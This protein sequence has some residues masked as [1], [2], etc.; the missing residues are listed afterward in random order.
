ML[1]NIGLHSVNYNNFPTGLFDP[2][3]GSEDV[4]SLPVRMDMGIMAT[5]GYSTLHRVK[6]QDPH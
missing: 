2:N 4:L 3:M 6:E 1:I 5:M